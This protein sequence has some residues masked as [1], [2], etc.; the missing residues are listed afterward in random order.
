M[1]ILNT[2]NKVEERIK[3]FASLRDN[4][5]NSLLKTLPGIEKFLVTWI[6]GRV[7]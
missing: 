1:T 2:N 4:E 6:E 7:Q 3:E 5:I